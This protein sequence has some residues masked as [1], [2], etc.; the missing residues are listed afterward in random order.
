MSVKQKSLAAGF[1]TVPA[2]L[3]LAACTVGPK[4]KKPA[5]PDLSGYTPAPV[6]TTSSAPGIGGGQAQQFVTGDI[7]GD[8][9]AL[10]HSK[11]L[12]DLIERSLKANPNLKAS[13][14][15]LL[16]ARENVLAQR[17]AYY[18]SLAGGFA[19]SHSK[20]SN[21]VSPFTASGELYYSLYTPQ[22]GVSFAP[23]V[24][25]LNRRTVESL[26][27]QQQQARFALAATHIT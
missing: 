1:L 21:Q 15:A 2:L 17:G 20:T 5:P 10:F 4:Y 7:P 24:F 6:S 14:A 13:Q 9:W 12:S 8:W 16:V 25:G 19:A 3:L 27:A 11:P 26:K 18:P 23:D 22:V